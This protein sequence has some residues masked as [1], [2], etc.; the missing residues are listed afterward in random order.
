[1]TIP[2]SNERIIMASQAI[3][4][5]RF[6][7][8]PY[9]EADAELRVGYV[10]TPLSG[11]DNVILESGTTYEQDETPFDG[12]ER[13]KPFL[14]RKQMY[15]LYDPGRN[16]R[17][18]DTEQ[19]RKPIRRPV[20]VGKSFRRFTKTISKDPAPLGERFAC[21]TNNKGM[22]GVRA[23]DGALPDDYRPQRRA[24]VADDVRFRH[25]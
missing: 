6:E 16:A 10:N 1:V 11:F 14:Q 18:T 2:R 20:L 4:A 22:E 15:L 8:L 5:K 12:E 24:G 25:R 21:R 13:D 3:Y 9:A 7:V 19:Y 17:P 23:R